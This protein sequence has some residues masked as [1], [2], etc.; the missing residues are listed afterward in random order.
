METRAELS[1]ASLAIDY[2]KRLMLFSGRVKPAAG[3]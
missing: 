3:G 2:S 1:G